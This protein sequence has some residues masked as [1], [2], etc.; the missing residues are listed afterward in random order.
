MQL[1]QGGTAVGTG[2]NAPI[3][4]AEKVAAQIAGITG[5]PFTTAPEQVRGPGSPRRRWSSATARSTWWPPAL[6]KIANDI[7]F[8]GSARAPAWASWSLPENEPG[9][10]DHAGQGQPDPVRGPHPGLRPG[11]RQPRRLTAIKPGA[12]ANF[13]S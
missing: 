8:L 3:G 6:F 9:S 12:R 10:L 13:S 7:R 4:F 5:L 11:V 1:A 2:L